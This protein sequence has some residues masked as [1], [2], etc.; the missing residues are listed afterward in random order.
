M[1]IIQKIR[2]RQRNK[3]QKFVEDKQEIDVKT[4]DEV[5]LSV[6]LDDCIKL[7]ET[8]GKVIA[9]YLDDDDSS[10]LIN[11]YRA[12]KIEI[13]ADIFWVFEA[14]EGYYELNFDVYTKFRSNTF[15]EEHEKMKK[16][17]NL[18]KANADE[19]IKLIKQHQLGGFNKK[20]AGID[21]QIK[22]YM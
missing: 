21:N 14:F 4:G 13:G 18:C 2:F 17:Y 3:K 16:L 9:R 15:V 7:L 6:L 12:D 11:V 8:P 20:L 10:S 22:Q 19:T 1:N 5:S